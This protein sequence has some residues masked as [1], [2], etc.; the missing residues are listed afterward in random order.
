MQPSNDDD[1]IPS[2][3]PAWPVDRVDDTLASRD[4]LRPYLLL[5]QEGITRF[6]ATTS[7]APCL[8]A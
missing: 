6:A 4:L 3:G 8:V 5:T 7:G 2:S 1:A